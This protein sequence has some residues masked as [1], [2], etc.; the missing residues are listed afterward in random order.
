MVRAL[1]SSGSEPR[2]GQA[3]VVAE[4]VDELLHGL[5]LGDDGADRADQDVLVGAFE[6]GFEL[7]LQAFGAE[8]DGGERVLDLVSEAAGHFAPGGAALG[9]DDLGD[10]VEHDG[11]S[12][13]GRSAP[14]TSRVS[15]SCA[16]VELQLEGFLP[17]VALTGLVL[18]L[19]AARQLGGEAGQ[20]WRFR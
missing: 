6:L 4:L 12:S 9:G 20:R 19:E 16:G 5:H 8:L 2:G 14:R 17:V 3:G 10:V 7:V 1:R 15:G 13:G 18:L 11:R